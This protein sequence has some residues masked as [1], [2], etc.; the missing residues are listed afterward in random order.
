[1]YNFMIVDDD[2]L[3]RERALSLIPTEQ[4]ELNL[5]GQAAD[6]IQAMELFELQRPQIVIMDIQIPFLNGI[7][8]AQKMLEKDPD[9][10]IIIITG[11]G[12]LEYAQT[13]L[14]SGITDFLVKPINPEELK[15]VLY[16]IIDMIRIQAAQELEQQRMERLLEREMP[17]IRSRYFLSLLQTPPENLTEEACR[18]Y[19]N[20][21]GING[22]VSDVCVVIVV[23]NYSTLSPS[24]QISMQSVLEKE[25]SKIA[26]T[27]D[28]GILVL[29]D[30][31]QRM[32]VI[33][34]S[35]AKINLDYIFEHRLS[36]IR[37]K[38]RYLYRF[39]FQAS[40]GSTVPGFRYL[41]ASYS[42]A[43][44]ALGYCGIFGNNNIIGCKSIP[45]MERPSRWVEW[46]S[47][48]EIT[49]MIITGDL[50]KIHNTLVRCLNQLTYHTHSSIHYTR[51]KSVELQ[52]LFL[53]C[54]RE[55]GVNT[56]PLLEGS[57]PLYA[58]ILSAANIF[59]IQ[60]VILE[61]AR[62]VIG[63]IQAKRKD[64]KNRALRSAKQY[65]NHNYA[66]PRLDLAA[67]SC[68]V[69]LSPSYMAQ[70]FHRY[71]NCS[72]TEYLNHVRVEQA[73]KLLLTT[74]MR[75][76]EVAQAVG[77]QNSK[78]FFQVFKQITGMRPREFYENSV[79]EA[80]KS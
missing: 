56:D 50:D 47:Y 6:G 51:Q 73:K 19:L 49:D 30:A 36:V 69:S 63:Q 66:N 13:A 31:M 39:D 16:K 5:I 26:D 55:L 72:F 41:N 25:L 68:S 1:M 24:D 57:H 46:P 75:I 15:N 64:S 43:S 78:Y 70:L 12:T 33:T 48:R 71:E 61:S 10:K 38:L 27:I 53:T 7:E 4:M 60:R 14:R 2:Q 29:Y 32:I 80:T 45:E 74:H 58:R 40:I 54:A 22:S 42:S 3:V 8:A 67:V 20:D 35:P 11:Y 28:I 62:E 17:L 37:D 21:F 34:Y 76:Y 79:C 44:H 18:Q 9:V 59:D 65:I 52:A 77:F 23:P